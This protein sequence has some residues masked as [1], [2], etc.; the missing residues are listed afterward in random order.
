M[1]IVDYPAQSPGLCFLCEA[2]NP[3]RYA[4]TFR[5]FDPQIVTKLNGRKYV[6]ESCAVELGEAFGGAS[7][8][9]T[10]EL[11]AAVAEANA[12]ADEAEKRAAALESLASAVAAVNATAPKKK[13]P[14]KKEA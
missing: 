6:C 12:R 14:V 4:D 3:V 9:K 2:T 5:H 7:A 8:A 1:N 13:A 10:A 11:K